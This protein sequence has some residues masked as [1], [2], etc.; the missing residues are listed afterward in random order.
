MAKDKEGLKVITPKFRAAFVRVFEPEAFD[1]SQEPKY[2]LTM[3]FPKD[4]DLSALKNAAREA[5]KRKWGD[6]PPKN[7]KSPF[8]DGD[9]MPY[10]GYEGCIAVSATSKWKPNVVDINIHQ[11]TDPEKFYSGCYARASVQAYAY[12]RIAKG[13]AFALINTQKLEEGEPFASRSRPEDD[14]D[15]EMS[16]RGEEALDFSSDYGF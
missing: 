13:V 6:K 5:A 10:D 16:Q 12:D 15:D 2:S 1:A 8:R 9:E 7:L 14:F 3:L 4:T 11:I